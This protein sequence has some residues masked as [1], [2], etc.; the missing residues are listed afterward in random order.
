L[1]GNF[2]FIVGKKV[3]ARIP[4]I[5]EYGAMADEQDNTIALVSVGKIQKEWYD[6]TLRVAQ[7]ET[8]RASL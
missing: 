5:D 8:E 3:M 6:L 1:Q 7:S 2:A 4:L